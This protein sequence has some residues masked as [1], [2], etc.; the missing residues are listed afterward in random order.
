LTGLL[1]AYCT[2]LPA[3]DSVG[4]ED[5]PIGIVRRDCPAETGAAAF[6][7]ARRASSRTGD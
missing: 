1:L 4:L 2:D 6:G 5:E 7:P 3:A